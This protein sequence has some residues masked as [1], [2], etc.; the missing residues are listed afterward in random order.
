MTSRIVEHFESIQKN[1]GAFESYIEEEIVHIETNTIQ[2]EMS[3]INVLTCTIDHNNNPH[4]NHPQ[5]RSNSG[6]KWP[7]TG[8]YKPELGLGLLKK[9]FD[10]INT[11]NSNENSQFQATNKI[12]DLD[13]NVHSIQQTD[14]SSSIIPMNDNCVQFYIDSNQ[15]YDKNNIINSSTSTVQM[16]V[17]PHAID[18]H[19]GFHN[20]HYHY[21]YDSN[22]ALS[23]DI[24]LTH[25]SSNDHNN[26][27]DRQNLLPSVHLQNFSSQS[28]SQNYDQFVSQPES[29]GTNFFD[30]E[31]VFPP[32]T[33]ESPQLIMNINENDPNFLQPFY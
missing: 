21:D 15:T 2:K 17:D 10:T 5:I 4:R 30:N 22:I 20:Q 19:N 12:D 27:H 9:L 24:F 23:P 28:L 6:S 11:G 18:N 7:C 1:M 31:S 16:A 33:L 29:P 13:N 14:H 32:I 26:Y 8:H 25:P 3:E